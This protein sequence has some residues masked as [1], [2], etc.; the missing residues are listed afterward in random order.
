MGVIP[1]GYQHSAREGSQSR[2]QR[3]EGRIVGLN[4]GPFLLPLPAALI[5]SV[6]FQ[7]L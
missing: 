6:G 7:G 5:K 3:R 2:L 4:L 1:I